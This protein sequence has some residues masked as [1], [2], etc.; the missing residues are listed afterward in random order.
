MDTS[1]I[2]VFI[3]NRKRIIELAEAASI[4]NTELQK[5]IALKIEIT[6]TE[7]RILLDILRLKHDVPIQYNKIRLV[8]LNIGASMFLKNK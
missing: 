2:S 7:I 3:T 8:D 1:S 6:T 5:L 4:A